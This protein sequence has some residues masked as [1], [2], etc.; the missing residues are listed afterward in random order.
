METHAHLCPVIEGVS[1]ITVN[2]G[3]QVRA[4]I[5]REA[6]EGVFGAGSDPQSWLKAFHAHEPAIVGMA[7]VRHALAPRERVV[8]LRGRHFEHWRDVHAV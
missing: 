2:A 8:L 1:F 6:L 4:L 5:L 7:R 3:V